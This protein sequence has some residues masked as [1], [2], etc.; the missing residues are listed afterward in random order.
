[1]ANLLFGVPP[2][3]GLLYQGGVRKEVRNLQK[4][5]TSDLTRLYPLLKKGD[6]GFECA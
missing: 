3:R 1:M 6:G 2:S 4:A 5:E